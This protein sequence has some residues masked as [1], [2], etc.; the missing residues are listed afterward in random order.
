MVELAPLAR[1]LASQAF[2]PLDLVGDGVAH[3]LHVSLAQPLQ[4]AIHVLDGGVCPVRGGED[5]G[6]LAQG[7]EVAECCGRDEEVAEDPRFW[8]RHGDGGWRCGVSVD[9]VDSRDGAMV[10]ARRAGG[11]A[12]RRA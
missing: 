9:S 4:L 2:G 3:K 1:I 10:Q 6:E 12:S 11:G 7:H 5:V 8:R